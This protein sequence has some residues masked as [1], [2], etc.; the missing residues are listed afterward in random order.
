MEQP[1]LSRAASA[2]G[3]HEVG[4]RPSFLHYL[5]DTYRLNG[6]IRIYAR[7]R[8]AT[9]NRRTRLG[10]AWNLLD[11]ALT[12][13]VYWILFGLLL[14]ARAS[15]PNYLGFLAIGVF[16]FALVRRSLQMGARSV[17]GNQGFIRS[18]PMP[19]AVFPVTAVVQ[20]LRAF[21]LSVPVLLVILIATGE[22]PSITWLLF[23][24]VIVVMIPFCLG[25]ALLLG[26][27][28]HGAPDVGG[29]LPLVL[30]LWGLLSG[31]MIPV[32]DRLAKIDAP[33]WLTG[34][35]EVN[36]PT[37]FL[38]LARGTLLSAD[39]VPGIDTWGLAAA[40]SAGLLIVGSVVFWR[41]EGGYARD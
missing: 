4:G 36:P 12:M 37:V 16:V 38:T 17:S 8:E 20:Q 22:R 25:A 28:V 15:V 27:W 7:A 29:I 26:R 24:V 10:F 41:G 19:A 14:Q 3:L 2:A 18:L 39:V 5:A 1:S 40:W 23:P 32:T 13:A 21:L 30:R 33:P 31:V 11:P 6:F 35:V 34:L 9:G